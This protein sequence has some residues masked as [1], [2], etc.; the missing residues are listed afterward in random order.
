MK[1]A[2]GED[3]LV[4]GWSLVNGVMQA[5]DVSTR[6]ERLTRHHLIEIGTDDS[7]WDVL[8][9]DPD[10]GRLWE[11]LYPKSDSHGSGPPMLQVLDH[12]SARRKYRA[13]NP[14]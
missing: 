11:L 12:E 3:K 13:L 6:I 2:P 4:G 10:D 8:Y 5:D 9:R 14:S 7:G 1:L